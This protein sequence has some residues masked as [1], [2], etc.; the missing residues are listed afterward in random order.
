[1]R[2][3]EITIADWALQITEGMF[4]LISLLESGRK[5]IVILQSMSLPEYSVK[6]ITHWSM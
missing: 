5:N 1:M 2:E 3:H 4:G 6:L